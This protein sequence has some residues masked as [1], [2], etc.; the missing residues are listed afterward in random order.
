[1]NIE[2]I[3]KAYRRQARYYDLYFGALFHRGRKAVIDRIGCRP[4]E[5]ILEVG[6]GTGLS[7]PMYPDDVFVTG[8]DI[9]PEMLERARRRR[10][11]D[12]LDNVTE[13]RLMDAEQMQFADDE[14]DKVVAMYVVPVVSNPKNLV[15]EMYRVCKPEG[16]LFIVNH[17]QS[18]NP[19]VGRLEQLISPLSAMIGFRTN[20]CLDNF[21]QETDLDVIERSGVNMFGY[22][23]MLQARNI[24]PP[25]I[26]ELVSMPAS[27][28]YA[29]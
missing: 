21:I 10:E 16:E 1:M 3:E 2:A 17:F 23:T 24:K 20:L 7:L 29:G 8:I 11:R 27:A 25:V 22:W 9:S 13:L 15:D 18:Q 6:V 12:E 4:G 5:K 28:G 14:F 19:L 26:E